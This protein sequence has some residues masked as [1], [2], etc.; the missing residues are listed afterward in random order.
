MWA[1][2]SSGLNG[3]ACKYYA[4][5]FSK[6]F[7]MFPNSLI[8]LHSYGK[9]T[10]ILLVLCVYMWIFILSSDADARSHDSAG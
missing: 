3:T 9:F 6:V 10:E 4:S 5:G 8:F 1:E 7:S 2:C